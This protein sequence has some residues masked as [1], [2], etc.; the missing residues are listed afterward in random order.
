[1]GSHWHG[2]LVQQLST[3]RPDDG[4]LNSTETCCLSANVNNKEIIM[5]VGLS[6]T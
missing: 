3:G 1:M 6:I 2:I 4:D 5:C